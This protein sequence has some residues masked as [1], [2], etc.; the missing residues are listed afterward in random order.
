MR[1]DRPN[2]RFLQLKD[3][4]IGFVLKTNWVKKVSL[5]IKRLLKSF[6]IPQSTKDQ[7]DR[8]FEVLKEFDYFPSYFLNYLKTKKLIGIQVYDLSGMN[9]IV[10]NDLITG[11][12]LTSG[13]HLLY[14]SHERF[15]EI[16]SVSKEFMSF[17]KHCRCYF[18]VNC[19][20]CL[21][22]T[23]FENDDE[24]EDEDDKVLKEEE[25]RIFSVI[26]IPEIEKEDGI[27][28]KTIFDLET[29][30]D[31]EGD[32]HPFMVCFSVDFFIFSL[33]KGVEIIK[34][35]GMGAILFGYLEQEIDKLFASGNFVKETEKFG[36]TPELENRALFYHYSIDPD[37]V[38]DVL[39]GTIAIKVVGI[40]DKIYEWMKMPQNYQFLRNQVKFLNPKLVCK[41]CVLISGSFNG[42]KFDELFLVKYRLYQHTVLKKWSY[43]I[44]GGAL[45]KMNCSDIVEE[46]GQKSKFFRF[47]F[48][49]FDLVRFWTSTLR[50][51]GKTLN[52]STQKGSMSFDMVNDFF[53]QLSTTSDW[54]DIHSDILGAYPEFKKR[55]IQ[56]EILKMAQGHDGKKINLMSQLLEYCMRDVIVTLLAGEIFQTK[57][58][59]ITGDLLS[60]KHVNIYNFIGTPAVSKRIMLMYS[61]KK[62]VNVE[63]FA[64][65][66]WAYDLIQ[67]CIIGGRSEILVVGKVEKEMC[68]V[69]INSM[70]AH[71][72][73]AP[74]PAGPGFIPDRKFVEK[75]QKYLD[76]CTFET[77]MCEDYNGKYEECISDIGF[78]FGYCKLEAPDR[79]KIQRFSPL[80]YLGKLGLVWS[81]ESRTQP[82]CSK[83]MEN[84][85][86]MGWKVT[87]NQFGPLLAFDKGHYLI[88]D[89]VSYYAEKRSKCT[90]P[91]MKN[92]Y[93]LLS[94]ALYG[95]MLERV[96][97]SSVDFVKS[98]DD[99]PQ[100]VNIP[101]ANKFIESTY[102]NET[103]LNE[104]FET[105][106][107]SLLKNPF[108]EEKDEET[109]DL[110]EGSFSDNHLSV[111]TYSRPITDD[112][113]ATCNQFGAF[114]LAYSR[115]LV[116][117]MNWYGRDKREDDLEVEEKS[118]PY[119]A[120]ETD[121][122][123]MLVDCYN[124]L[125]KNIISQNEVGSWDEA[126]KIFK[127]KLKVEEFEPIVVSDSEDEDGNVIKGSKT[128]ANLCQSTTNWYL[129]KKFYGVENPDKSLGK[130]K[131]ACKGMSKSNI[132]IGT[133]QKCFENCF[134]SPS[135]KKICFRFIDRSVSISKKT[136]QRS[137]P[138][139]RSCGKPFESTALRSH[140]LKRRMRPTYN[141][142]R[143]HPKH[144]EDVDLSE[145]YIELLPFDDLNPCP[146][147]EKLVS[148]DSLK[149]SHLI[150]TDEY[151][152]SEEEDEFCPDRQNFIL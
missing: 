54:K 30:T 105:K 42:Q 123:H 116:N 20:K 65:Q 64:P 109:D 151:H 79:K 4:S 53:N 57:V 107:I 111:V 69:D 22:K 56:S 62:D 141:T 16:K 119:L 76:R 51:V 61:Q 15:L 118:L 25:N 83:D 37:N 34:R 47:E 13:I 26:K 132:K 127:F 95:K 44:K 66:S 120:S 63:L 99:N 112:S 36:I 89:L 86:R 29:Y 3:P 90:D 73:T 23:Y 101:H 104:Q 150:S 137:L 152:F 71:C 93:K 50:S 1:T 49:T 10:G 12:E 121:S 48:K 140:V 41:K 122:A 134:Y 148:N 38:C 147:E 143:V 115:D 78:L 52:L 28:I 149:Q 144:V 11:D 17:C 60:G 21:E 6:L 128:S 68:F 96:S 138:G 125:D 124:R 55:S 98:C 14:S 45:Y 58:D 126:S 46:K 94:N 8:D 81:N 92:V 82:L 131:I 97:T 130:D 24:D 39:S 32:I 7:L 72:M 145:S 108:S 5:L 40:Q 33:E 18:K 2:V 27:Y 100:F 146:I 75:F 142:K 9:S 88:R 117:H 135:E 35:D 84:V 43:T 110:L 91:A 114:I 103:G 70:Y 77:G 106:F 67:K 113:N 80:P 85:A 129:A 87:I 31:L 59:A 19:K 74:M 102:D 139:V 133:F 136:M